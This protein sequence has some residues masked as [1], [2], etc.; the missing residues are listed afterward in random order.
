MRRVVLTLCGVLL[1][2]AADAQIIVNSGSTGADGA[3][4]GALTGT[5]PRFGHLPPGTQILC[6]GTPLFPELPCT[7]LVP[8]REPPNH[9]FNFTTVDV[10]P[11]VTVKFIRNA[12]NTPVFILAAGAVDIDGTIDVSGGRGTR[13]ASAARGGPGGFDGGI[14]GRTSGAGT[15]ATGGSGS[16]P[17]GG[18]GIEVTDNGGGS[19]HGSGGGNACFGSCYGTVDLRPLIGGSGGASGAVDSTGFKVLGNGGGGGGAI[20]IASSGTIS[21]GSGSSNAIVANGGPPE[22]FPFGAVGCGSGGAVRLVANAIAGNR[23]VSAFSGQLDPISKQ[24]LAAG[25]VRFETPAGEAAPYAGAVTP[26]PTYNLPGRPIE[27]FP[28]VVPA[29]RIVTINGTPLPVQPTVD[30][31]TPDLAIDPGA[32]ATT[33]NI[34]VVV[35]EATHVPSGTPVKV[36]VKPQA[37]AG[38]SSISDPVLL[39]GP[40]AACVTM[41]GQECMTATLTVPI[42]ANGAGLI[43]AVIDSVTPV[44]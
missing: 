33:G 7:L 10:G 1:A 25:R 20:L 37:G 29:L 18:S 30:V 31:T 19:F 3:F 35:V 28:P 32:L 11:G 6:G 17:G 40:P 39:V 16:G 22:S 36:M 41:A 9:V 14:A 34:I 12:S 23:S 24:P 42:A 8:L 5:P 4:E 27:I 15:S 38:P 26:A 43:S 21:L 13:S 2:T 44:R